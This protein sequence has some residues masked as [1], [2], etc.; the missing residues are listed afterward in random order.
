MAKLLKSNSYNKLKLKNA[1]LLLD[2]HTLIMRPDSFDAIIIKA[3]YKLV[4]DLEKCI[5]NGHVH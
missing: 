1:E 4:F 2:I 5:F 3:R